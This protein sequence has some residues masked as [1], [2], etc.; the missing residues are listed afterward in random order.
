MSKYELIALDM[1]GTLLNS[2]LKLSEGNRDAVERAFQA[3]KQVIL[4]TGRC[5]C[6]IRDTLRQLPQI[7]YLVCEN[8]SC[9]YDCKYDQ[10]IHVEPVPVEEVKYILKLVRGERCV[11]QVFH[12]NQSYFHQAD[13][14]WADAYR[15]GNY[16]GVFNRCGVWDAKLF[17]HYGERPFR[18]EKINLYFDNLRTRDQIY[19][20]LERRPLKLAL[21]IGYMFEAVSAKADKGIGLK[22]LCDH[23]GLDVSKTIAMGDSA[24]D[25]EILRA[26]GFSAAMGNACAEAKAA[27]DIVTADCDHD[28]VAKVIDEYLLAE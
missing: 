8:G 17:D 15:V 7:R 14:R 16:K 12:E 19:A 3:G 5:L 28:G 13:D 1:D 22:K 11:V 2:E 27:A 21:S 6:E 26:A 24:N 20:I 23:L 18:I 9:V 10:T 4:S 25:L